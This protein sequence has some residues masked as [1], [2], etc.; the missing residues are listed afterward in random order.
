MAIGAADGGVEL[1][2][3]DGLLTVGEDDC[4]DAPPVAPVGNELA[5]DLKAMSGF[6]AQV[7]CRVAA[8]H[9]D[10]SSSAWWVTPNESPNPEGRR[11]DY[12]RN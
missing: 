11:I 12:G 6:V 4:C 1:T 7:F 5:F 10:D 3:D 9:D 8:R 2:K